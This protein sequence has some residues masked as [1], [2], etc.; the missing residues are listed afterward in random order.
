MSVLACHVYVLACH[1][2]VLAC[3]VYVLACHVCTCN[4]LWKNKYDSRPNG[5]NV[6]KEIGTVG[7]V[8]DS[9]RWD[10]PY[11][12]AGMLRAVVDSDVFVMPAGGCAR[13][14]QVL[15]ALL[16]SPGSSVAGSNT[17]RVAYCMVHG[18]RSVELPCW[19]A[20]ATESG[21]PAMGCGGHA[22]K[23]AHDH[24]QRRLGVRCRRRQQSAHSRRP[25]TFQAPRKA[26]PVW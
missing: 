11:A 26:S 24:D 6:P 10:R 8:P 1:V 15:A 20:V 7:A 9:L 14:V 16:H 2:Y 5:P 19:V 12:T 21:L 13:K 25:P 23:P 3:H 18:A 22:S 4:S 17:V